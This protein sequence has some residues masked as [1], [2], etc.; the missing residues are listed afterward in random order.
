M[1]SGYLRVA[2]SRWDDVIIVLPARYLINVFLMK[3]AETNVM[4]IHR[5]SL[6]IATFLCNVVCECFFLQVKQL[7]EV[8]SGGLGGL[9]IWILPIQVVLDRGGHFFQF[10]F[11]AGAGS[12]MF[13]VSVLSQD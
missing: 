3:N 10:S 8:L 9:R 5:E 1:K 12:L 4:R 13:I 11:D 6:N 7:T 2:G